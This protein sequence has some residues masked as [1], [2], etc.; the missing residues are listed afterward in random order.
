TDGVNIIGEAIHSEDRLT[1]GRRDGGLLAV[2]TKWRPLVFEL[3]MR[4]ATERG[5]PAQATSAGLSLFGSQAASGGFGLGSTNTKIDP[6]TGQPIV[7]PGFGPQLSSGVNASAPAA[8][9]DV[10]TVR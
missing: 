5:A 1:D 9:P 2:E 10:M 4:R 8:S 7:E 3:G 6:A